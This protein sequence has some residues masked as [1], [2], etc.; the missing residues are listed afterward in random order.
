MLAGALS[1]ADAASF[2]VTNTNASGDGS[3]SQAITDAN[4]AG[5]ADTIAFAPGVTGTIT[6]NS[7]DITGPTTITGPGASTLTISGRVIVETTATATISDLTIDGGTLTGGSV[8]PGDATGGAGSTGG[9]AGSSATGG[10]ATGGFVAGGAVVNDGELVVD[11]V[12]V[13][14]AQG[15]AGPAGGATGQG[16]AGGSGNGPGGAGGPGGSGTSGSGAAGDVRGTGIF[17][18]G[19]MTIRESTIT[20]NSAVAGDGG[21]ANAIG[22]PGGNG[23]PNVVGAGPG[24]AGGAG[25]STGASGGNVLGVGIYNAGTMT[26]EG[27][28][29]TGNTATAGTGGDA[30]ATGGSGGVIVNSP[31]G[32]GGSATAN[33]GAGGDALGAGVFN[34]G[35]LEL[36]NS[37]ISGNTTT[38]SGK[39]GTATA[40]NGGS[41]NGIPGGQASATPGRAGIAGGGGF[42]NATSGSGSATL[43]SVT[44]ATNRAD[45]GA[46]LRSTGTLTISNSIIANPN[47]GP[48][49]DGTIASGGFN[50]DSGTSCGFTQTSDQQSTD[51]QLGLLQ[52]NGGPT[53]THA[54]AQT[55]PAVDHGGGGG[56]T[57]DQRGLPRPSDFAGIAN[58]AGGDGSDIGAVELAAPPGEEPPART[59]LTIELAASPKQKGTK[60]RA[61]V[62]CSKDCEL[63]AQ[64]K[65][66]AGGDKFKTK[67]TSLSLSAGV[68]KTVKLKLKKAD[69]K[70]VAGEKG[71]ATLSVSATAGTEVATDKTKVKLK[72]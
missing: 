68:A 5:G 35:T 67:A 42:Q 30:H 22:G 11:R 15:T 55:S 7:L 59:P 41:P 71:K 62:T 18:L 12:V 45:L 50:I 17:N 37:T 64:G 25:A 20:G 46:N 63:D 4:N 23:G 28:T 43:R 61:T 60:L 19:S 53:A 32:T 51:P 48:N 31:G 70:D 52:D 14:G 47:A 38:A 26:I 39:A 34:A 10:D 69:R 40:I 49:C 56:L 65:G 16:G 24:G 29:V 27:S 72:S 36:R 8:S 66:K 58:A 3:L 44:L 33:G 57:T 9:G 21:D 6:A 2:Q 13:T 54:P 1:Q